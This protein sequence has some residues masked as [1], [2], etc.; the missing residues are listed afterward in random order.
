MRRTVQQRTYRNLCCTWYDFYVPARHF[1]DCGDGVANGAARAAGVT[2]A[3]T[4]AL[5]QRRQQVP[6]PC[7]PA[8]KPVLF[9]AISTLPL[10][11][12]WSLPLGY[13]LRSRWTCRRARVPRRLRGSLTC[14]HGLE[15]HGLRKRPWLRRSRGEMS[16]SLALCF[17]LCRLRKRVL[18]ILTGRV[19][20]VDN[21]LCGVFFMI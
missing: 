4:R 3:S 20:L 15:R 2:P 6:V 8:M 21:V 13:E 12:H 11:G 16:M 7:T 1:T 17:L 9:R 14:V 5:G 10:W 19:S 18:P